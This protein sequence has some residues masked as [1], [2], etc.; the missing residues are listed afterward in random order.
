[1]NTYE[2][3]QMKRL[4]IVINENIDGLCPN[5]DDKLSATDSA[6][7]P[8]WSNYYDNIV[9]WDCATNIVKCVV[10]LT[11]LDMSDYGEGGHIHDGDTI[12]SHCEYNL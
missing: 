9:C 8:R 11:D 10:C 6:Y 12:C 7:Q 3:E 2:L 5:C 1:M 4:M